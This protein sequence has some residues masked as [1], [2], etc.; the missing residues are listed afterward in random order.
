[1][2]FLGLLVK[3]NGGTGSADLAVRMDAHRGEEFDH[4]LFTLKGLGGGGADGFLRVRAEELYDW[5]FDF[6][7]ALVIEWSNPAAEITRWALEVRF[8]DA[9]SR[10]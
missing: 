1:M 2:V 7:D 3:F 10:S 9:S 4:T 5:I 6:G 8:A